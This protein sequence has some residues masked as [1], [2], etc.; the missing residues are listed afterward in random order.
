MVLQ[1]V[2]NKAINAYLLGKTCSEKEEEKAGELPPP[3]PLVNSPRGI[4]KSGLAGR[5]EGER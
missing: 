3:P 4:N 1:S 5:P 2:T